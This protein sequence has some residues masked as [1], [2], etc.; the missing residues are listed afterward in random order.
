MCGSHCTNTGRLDAWATGGTKDY[1]GFG[2][3][4]F[5]S[6]TKSVCMCLRGY[7][8][9]VKAAIFQVFQ[10][11]LNCKASYTPSVVLRTGARGGNIH[12]MFQTWELREIKFCLIFTGTFISCLCFL[13]WDLRPVARVNVG[14]LR[15]ARRLPSQWPLF[16]TRFNTFQPR[17]G[18]E[19]RHFWQDVGI[20]PAMFSVFCFFFL[21]RRSNFNK[22]SGHFEPCLWQKKQ[23]LW[24]DIGAFWALFVTPNKG[25]FLMTH[26]GNSRRQ[27]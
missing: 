13:M 24:W 5:I 17:L 9:I 22:T 21:L 10:Q 4:L 25:E 11:P 14:S 26:Q 8:Y 19:T 12:T 15:W 18:N 3:Q 23:Y 16:K 27:K 1:E 20:F 7:A 2:A 6:S